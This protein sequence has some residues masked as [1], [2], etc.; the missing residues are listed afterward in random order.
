MKTSYKLIGVA[1]VALVALTGVAAATGG[2][3]VAAIDGQV[4]T[5]GNGYG[6]GDGTGNVTDARPMDGTNSPWVAGD[7]R[8]DA[9]QERFDLTDDQVDAIRNEVQSMIDDGA[10]QGEIR[11]TVTEML[12]SFGVEDPTLGPPTDGGQGEGPFGQGAGNGGGQGAGNAGQG[13]GNGGPNGPA[14]GSCQN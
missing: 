7:E 10:T 8:L 1:V 9:F 5:D 6:P 2:A 4:A 13:A 12:E 14:D 3:G 11:A